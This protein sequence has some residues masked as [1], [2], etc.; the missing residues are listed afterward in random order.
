MQFVTTPIMPRANELRFAEKMQF[1]FFLQPSMGNIVLTHGVFST[2]KYGRSICQSVQEGVTSCIQTFDVQACKGCKGESAIFSIF[3]S[4]L[5][6]LSLEKRTYLIL[7]CLRPN[8]ERI[9]YAWLGGCVVR[10]QPS[11]AM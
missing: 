4:L 8:D 10:Q 6:V 11:Q 5:H 9:C 1:C 3:L 2:A 7:F